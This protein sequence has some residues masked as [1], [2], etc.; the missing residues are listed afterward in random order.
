MGASL[1]KLIQDIMSPMSDVIHQV[2]HPPTCTFTGGFESVFDC[3]FT[4][5]SWRI[6]GFVTIVKF[7]NTQVAKIK[8]SPEIAK[9]H[10]CQPFLQPG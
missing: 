7:Q 1:S 3:W 4:I 10:I 2:N 6:G 9:Y 5:L 8:S